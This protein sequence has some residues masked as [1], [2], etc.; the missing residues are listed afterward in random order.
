[1]RTLIAT[2]VLV[3]A[4]GCGGGEDQTQPGTTGGDLVQAARSLDTA[5]VERAIDA[6]KQKQEVAGAVEALLKVLENTIEPIGARETAAHGLGYLGPQA[7]SA[8][9][10]L[11]RL[12][13]EDDEEVI[14]KAA[15][16]ALQKISSS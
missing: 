2:L 5:A 4:A 7:A 10:A 16:D 1:M 15:G 11:Q 3:G 8:A 13:K 9:A 14:K 12:A 6:A